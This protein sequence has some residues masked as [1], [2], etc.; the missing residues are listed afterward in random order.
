MSEPISIVAHAN[1]DDAYVVWRYPKAIPDCRGFALYRKPKGGEEEAVHTFIPFAGEEHKPGE[2]RP[3]SEWPIQKFGWTDVL[4]RAGE[5]VSYRVVPMVGKAGS[6][7][8]AK[9]QASP[10]SDPVEVSADAGDGLSAYFNRG[11]L[12]TQSVARRLKADE[13]WTK[14]LTKMIETKGDS[15]R[16]YLSGELRLAMRKILAE[17]NEN[18]QAAI[19]AALFELDDPELIADLEALGPRAHIVLANGPKAKVDK[20]EKARLSLRKAGVDVYDRMTV[21]G[22]A[23]NK[24][25]VLCEPDDSPRRVWTGSTNWSMTGLCTQVNNGILIDSAAV[26][27]YYRKQW[28]ALRKAGNEFTEELIAANSV[29]RSAKLPDGDIGTWFA[30]VHDTIDLADA[31]ELIAAAKQGALF[32]FFIPGRKETLFNAIMDRA[33]PTSS[34]YDPN[35][36]VHGVVNQ[37]P[38]QGSKDPALVGLVHRGQLDQ[39]DPDVVMPSSVDKRFAAWD[40]EIGRYNIVM[41]HSK[42]VLL[43]PFGEKPVVMTGSHNMGPAA[44]G[45]NDDNLNLIAGAPKLAAAYATHIISVY[46]AYRWRYLRSQAAK[47]AGN[48]WEG[49][50]DG[51]AWQDAYYKGVDAEAKQRELSFWL[52][53]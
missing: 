14:Q 20:S 33:D 53:E 42:V 49:P 16:D 39:A 12:A 4:A 2:H 30:P 34:N 37:D 23:H 6:L 11:V 35:L 9:D 36:Y 52:G 48:E 51:K 40:K 44:S 10:W 43:D 27:V 17:V 21:S 41:V 1:C 38:E 47:A 19:Y 8:E 3:S 13:P 46:N 26:A 15:T 32:L 25:M 45:D 50:E 24:F 18:P 31:R 7:T 29:K 28:D 22:L 5:T